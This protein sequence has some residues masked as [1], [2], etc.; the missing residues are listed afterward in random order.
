[1]ATGCASAPTGEAVYEPIL[2]DGRVEVEA[3]AA[4]APGFACGSAL[5]GS[6]SPIPTPQPLDDDAREALEALRAKGSEGERFVADYEYGI[7]SRTDDELILLGTGFGG[8]LSDAR[9]RYTNGQW[10]PVG[11]GTCWW[12]PDG[13]DPVKWQVDPDHEL[14]PESRTILIL[15]VDTCGNVLDRG[16]EAVVVA[17]FT[18]ESVTIEVWEALHPSESEPGFVELSCPLGRTVPLMVRLVEPIGQRA[19]FGA[20]L[21]LDGPISQ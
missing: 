20:H 1:M 9:F 10:D 8:T 13:F 2:T 17:D 14:D 7:H 18:N 5:V 3:V 19:I 6:G 21:Y 12:R 16:Y 15:A 11:W 4:F